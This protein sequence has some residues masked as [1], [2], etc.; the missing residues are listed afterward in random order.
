MRRPTHVAVIAIHDVAPQTLD[1]ADALRRRIHA[2]AGA[3]PVSLLV[4]PRYHDRPAWSADA[5]HWVRTAAARG[6]E[7]VTHG[8]RHL[9]AHGRDGR[10]FPRRMLYPAAW[11][12]VRRA[13]LRMAE[14]GFPNAGFIAPAYGHPATLEYVLRDL[15]V[16]WW[17]TR[18]ALRGPDAATGLPS[19][20]LGAS[21]T[22]RR[23]MSPTVASAGCR[24]LGAAPALRLD[25]HPADLAHPR[26]REAVPRLLEL[27]L[28][29]R[30]QMITH[31]QLAAG[32][33]AGAG[34]PQA[35]DDVAA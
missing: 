23:A 20:G 2:V 31:A 6:D 25:L 30:R 32:L 18:G 29:Q 22:V 21:S 5:V 33:R 9:D 35:I 13:R 19:I 10:E 8:F 14:L 3:V 17:A 7:V 27:L 28:H 26:L 34:A 11:D 4:V 15:G 16:A 24:A 12:L 1:N